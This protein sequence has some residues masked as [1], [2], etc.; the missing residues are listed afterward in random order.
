MQHIFEVE[1]FHL[2]W[3][4]KIVDP[5]RS[6]RTTANQMRDCLKR[7]VFKAFGI[8]SCLTTASLGF[9]LGNQT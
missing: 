4:F 5:L 1:V 8:G 2:G 3:H 6:P 7:Q 9:D